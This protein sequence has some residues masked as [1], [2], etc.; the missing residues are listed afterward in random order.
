MSGGTSLLEPCEMGPFIL[1]R[2]IRVGMRI[3]DHNSVGFLKA[4]RRQ[5]TESDGWLRL[6]LCAFALF[7]APVSGPIARQGH[8]GEFAGF[9]AFLSGHPKLSPN[10]RSR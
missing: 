9:L 6:P 4:A 3:N 2:T 5:L 8:W 7:L 10:P 1:Y